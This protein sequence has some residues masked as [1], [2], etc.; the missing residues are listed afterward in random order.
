MAFT[1]K[2]AIIDK[3]NKNPK[4]GQFTSVLRNYIND[5]DDWNDMIWDLTNNNTECQLYND[6][7]GNT[8]FLQYVGQLISNAIGDDINEDDIKKTYHIKSVDVMHKQLDGVYSEGN[9]TKKFIINNCDGNVLSIGIVSDSLSVDY[10]KYGDIYKDNELITHGKALNNGDRV[11]VNL[12]FNDGKCMFYVNNVNEY[13]VQLTS[14][15]YRFNYKYSSN[16]KSK[17][18]P[19]EVDPLPID[20]D[21]DVKM[22]ISPITQDRVVK[23]KVVCYSLDKK[24]DDDD[25]C[26]TKSCIKKPFVII[27][28]NNT[29]ETKV[30]QQLYADMY[31][32]N[33]NCASTGHNNL[34]SIKKS[35]K[36]E[37]CANV[38]TCDSVIIIVGIQANV[39]DTATIN[40]ASLTNIPEF[41]DPNKSTI[42]FQYTYVSEQQNGV[43]YK[44]YSAMKVEAVHKGNGALIQRRCDSVLRF[45]NIVRIHQAMN[46]LLQ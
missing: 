14:D 1:G 23:P 39:D 29:S 11:D 21:T 32:F 10:D 28:C 37:Y 36:K 17:R 9:T 43:N 4:Y 27:C 7:N 16:E 20:V 25:I 30:L 44:S 12:N 22:D 5:F 33:I 19:I 2:Q 31:G 15:Q 8:E 3:I 46:T 40:T 13:E 26:N 45:D 35:V 6:T 24:M 38:G 34:G 18:D 42:L 41:I